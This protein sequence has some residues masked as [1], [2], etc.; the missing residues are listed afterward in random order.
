[1]AYYETSINIAAT[2]EKVWSVIEDI[3]RWPRWT[4]SMTSVE[5]LDRGP[6]ARGSRA[7]VK[8]P[9]LPGVVW[10]VTD[11]EPRRSYTW[12]ARNPGITSVADH[13]LSP[14][15]DDTVTVRLSVR[16]TGPLAPLL[17]LLAS[18]LTRRYVNMEAE[19][20]K[21]YCEADAVVP[22]ASLSEAHRAP[23]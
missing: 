1:M 11:L 19:G 22:P 18:G 3:E 12:T 23:A 17:G 13:Q 7:H 10:T 21:R 5:R 15:P 9:K 20:L 4:A 14:G 6:L 16:Q 8:Q 2:P